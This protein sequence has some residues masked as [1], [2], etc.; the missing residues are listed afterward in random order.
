MKEKIQDVEK[1]A[2]DYIHQTDRRVLIILAVGFCFAALFGVLYGFLF[3]PDTPN[4]YEYL[5]YT[6]DWHGNID[7]ALG[8]EAPSARFNTMEIDQIPGGP[9]LTVQRSV[10]QQ[11]APPEHTG[12]SETKRVGIGQAPPDEHSSRDEIIQSYQKEYGD[13]WLRQ[14]K[15]D[16]ILDENRFSPE[17]FRANWGDFPEVIQEIEIDDKGRQELINEMQ[18]DGDLNR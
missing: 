9:A 5:R 12:L 2:Q 16:V 6:P 11:E 7:M 1:I 15:K 13:D 3:Q 18:R 4:D 14:M 8:Y 17:E 10:L